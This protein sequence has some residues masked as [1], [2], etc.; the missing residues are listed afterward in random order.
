MAENGTQ[1]R[2]RVLLADDHT[3]FREGLAGSLATYGEDVEIVG[4]IPNDEEAVALAE[5]EKPDV[6][7]MQIERPIEKAKEKISRLLSLSP[8]PQVLIVTMFGDPHYMHE[9]LGSG[10]SAYLLKDARVEELIEVIRRVTTN[11]DEA[12]HMVVGIPRE[13]LEVPEVDSQDVLS[14][15]EMEVL[16]LAAHGL[17]NRRIARSL[18]ISEATV[19]RH[20][21][22]IYPKMGVSSRGE[23]VK[24]ALQEG[25]ISIREIT[26]G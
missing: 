23:A 13:A 11:P 19:K 7:I 25:W 21:A 8:R 26:G 20:L 4:A 24:K 15:R 12:N 10:A 17:S 1:K 22:N 5:R 9:L 16:L 6:V 2:V 3:L 18:H 14:D